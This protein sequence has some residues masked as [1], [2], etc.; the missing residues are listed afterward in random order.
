MFAYV[1]EFFL[2]LVEFGRGFQVKKNI[3]I[4]NCYS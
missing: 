4:Y 3:N 2:T 1:S